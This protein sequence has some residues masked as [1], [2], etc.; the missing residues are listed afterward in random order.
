MADTDPFTLKRP[1]AALTWGDGGPVSDVSG[2]V[3]FSA[4]NGLEETRAVFLAGAGFPER[5]NHDLTVVGELGFG[6]G[7]N[8]LGLWRLFLDHAPDDARLHFIT[9]EGWPLR[10]E[11][12]AKALSA[13]AE[14]ADL[15]APL[16][17]AWPSPHKGAHRRVFAE[18]RVTLTVFHDESEAAL[19]NMAFQADAWF[20]DGFSP[21]K[22]PDMW[23]PALFQQI[24]RLSKPGAPAATF[25]V[26][27]AVRRG[28][29]EA[30]FAVEKRPGFGRKRE[31][32]EAIYQGGGAGQPKPGFAR[33][34][35][36]SGAIAIIGG[37]IAAASVVEA[38]RRRGRTPT[39]FAKGGWASGAS[40]AP[41]G[42]LTP[43][44]EAAD[45]PHN[46][47]LLAAFDYAARLYRGA[48]WLDGEGVLRCASD[49]RGRAR[50]LS[51]ADQL[52]DRFAWCD[53]ADAAA[54]TGRE[55]EAGL[56]MGAAGAFQPEQIVRGLAAE[57]APIDAEI[58]GLDRGDGGWRLQ[59]SAGGEHGPFETV[60]IAGG[61]AGGGLGPLP[62]EAT[63]G[64][65]ACFKTSDKLTA[66]VAWGG[67]GAPVRPGEVLVG[68]THIKSDAPGDAAD[69]ERELR[70]SLQDGPLRLDVGARTQVW[71]G[72]RAATAD[73]LPVCGLTPDE[74]FADT[75]RE[76]ARRGSAPNGTQDG[77]GGPILLTAFGARGFAHAPLLAEE[78]VSALCGE[79][80]AFEADGL[81][82]LHPARFAWR[83]LRRGG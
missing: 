37:G 22:N 63:A 4:E 25:T 65:V 17:G 36:A 19:A 26:A 54:R 35:A 56:W 47:A 79:P 7:L 39:V 13:F 18:G 70:A 60:I 80:S 11:D 32:L 73:R 74:T 62:L 45:R 71:G 15:A 81:Q 42:L 29:A 9:M 51:L 67:Y 59:D 20:L 41:L 14:L 50:L 55:T 46:R 77:L 2:D 38:L 30:G 23:T 3:Y 5:F 31:R 8:F 66:P 57:L 24:A 69:A 78:L 58:T 33:P 6:T 52:D 16:I 48:G 12:A 72:V 76:A 27:G 83:A 28:L 61:F 53:S 43:R 40:G 75:W 82:A 21:A 10:R 44:L 49:A 34:A 1:H 68:A 64:Q